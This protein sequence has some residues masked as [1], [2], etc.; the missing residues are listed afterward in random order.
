MISCDSIKS[1]ISLASNIKKL[2]SIFEEADHEGKS[3][4][5]ED[6]KLQTLASL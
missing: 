3:K 4:K 2:Y 6:E 1:S 5:F